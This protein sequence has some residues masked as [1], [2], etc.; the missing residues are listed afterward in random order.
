ML[1]HSLRPRSVLSFGPDTEAIPLRDMN[2][3]IGPNGSGKSNLLEVIAL[4]K[5][6]PKAMAEPIRE[7]G[8]IR[9]WLW[10]GSS[11]PATVSLETTVANL[12]G[13]M[14]LC[15]RVPFTEQAHR[16]QTPS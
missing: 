12:N 15:Y 11:K 14:P 9:D 1:I 2:V 5:S 4:L 16:F 7:G 13:S 8:G 10:K 6:A 3:I